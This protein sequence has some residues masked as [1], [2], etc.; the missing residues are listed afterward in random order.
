MISVIMISKNGKVLPCS[1]RLLGAAV[2]DV[3]GA[4]KE[5]DVS[6]ILMTDH[7]MR[8]RKGAVTSRFNHILQEGIRNHL[9]RLSKSQA[10]RCNVLS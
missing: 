4:K 9:I 1:L 8:L 3:E 2:V 6:V 10:L 5:I 7:F